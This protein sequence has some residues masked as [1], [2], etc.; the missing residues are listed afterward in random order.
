VSA[1][2]AVLEALADT[3]RRDI[4]ERLKHGP[5]A[6]NEIA[7]GLP[8]S[9]PAVSQHLRV[10]LR[11]GLVQYEAAGTRNVYRLERTGLDALRTW[12]DAFWQD[13]LDAFEAYA[14]DPTTNRGTR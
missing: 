5:A 12:L 7:D 14:H 13:V 9:R 8:I 3:T 10:L 1:Y 4:L 2:Q 11:A 6:V